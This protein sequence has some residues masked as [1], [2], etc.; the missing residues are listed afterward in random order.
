M[1]C[2]P[3][4]GRVDAAEVGSML[5][6]LPGLR[7]LVL[8]FEAVEGWAPVWAA[9][10]E[11]ACPGLKRLVVSPGGSGMV[12]SGPS[13]VQSIDLAGLVRALHARGARGCA[14]L[15]SLSLD[16]SLDMEAEGMASLAAEPVLPLQRLVLQCRVTQEDTAAMAAFLRAPTAQRLTGLAVSGAGNA[17][18]MPAD[19]VIEALAESGESGSLESR[20]K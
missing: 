11:G 8:R 17:P 14:P 12:V 1:D 7:Q 5:H 16:I 6:L 18:I 3:M 13:N 19:D 9:L 10:A 20:H 15:Q 4:K 2:A